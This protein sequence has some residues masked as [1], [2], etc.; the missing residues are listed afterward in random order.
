M[1]I[2][3]NMSNSSISDLLSSVAASYEIKDPKR[4]KFKIIAYERAASG[5]E[6]VGSEIK[7]LWEE[8]KLDDIPGIGPSI[9]KH[10]DEIFRTGK[11]AHF[12]KVLSGMP[13][14]MFEFM[15][16]KGL[17]AKTS[18]K[19]AKEL[20]IKNSKNALKKLETAI[21]EGRVSKIEGLG[22]QAASSILKSVKDTKERKPRLLLS[23][24]MNVADTMIAWMEKSK[25]VVDADPLGSLRRKASTI[26]DIDISVSSKDPKACMDH[27]VS[28]PKKIRVLEKGEK[29]SSIIVSGGYQVDLMVQ[30]PESYGSLLQHFTGSKHHNIALREYALKRGF[31]LSEYGVKKISSG[32]IN[33]FSNEE[34]FYKFLGLD[35]IA[36]EIR[37][38]AGEIE[39][40]RA[41]K[42][43][44]LVELSEI[45]GDLQIHSS[46]DIETSHD[47]GESSMEEI[48]ETANQLKYEYI[49]FT[50][51]NP[52]R[53]GH[54][55]KE[56][57]KLLSRKKEKIEKINYSLKKSVKGSMKRVFNSLEID[58]LPDGSLPVSEEGLSFLDFA[59]VSI[60]SSFSQTK[61]QMTKRILTAL[62]NPK[63]KIFAHPTAR[64]LNYRE[65]IEAN[66]DEIFKYSSQNNK[67]IEINADPMRL[68]LP[69]YLIR[70]AIKY[71]VIFSMGTDSHHKSSM[72]NMK[73]GVYNAR[74]GWACASDIAVTRNLAQFEKL[75]HD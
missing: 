12:E 1:K 11:S 10:L 62:K 24:A 52:S 40:A 31:S 26:G 61:I 48:V 47:L 33:K 28:Y 44:K 50:E 18:F 69:D 19:L 63:V 32:K 7:D 46:F 37:E 57:V 2:H 14:S 71:G 20:D 22:E 17:G 58:I 49:A 68:D 21:K 9:A 70:D 16:V 30:P 27:F 66:W 75:L 3:R 43:P 6:H 74:R 67:W 39:A 25:S 42:I 34:D 4:N 55:E 60:H 15:K 64:K 51:H 73:Y 45:R 29:S 35:Y 23:N 5:V 36:P 54:N 53:R 8:G 13:E 56:I 38:D 65:S 72:E 41:H 59:L